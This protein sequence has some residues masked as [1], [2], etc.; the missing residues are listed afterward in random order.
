MDHLN[1]SQ[2]IHYSIPHT[3]IMIE[4]HTR[5]P[6][7][8]TAMRRTLET[9]LNTAHAIMDKHGNV[10]M[11][12]DPL[13]FTMPPQLYTGLEI[14]ARSTMVPGL[15]WIDFINVIHGLEQLML[16]RVLYKEVHV[17]MFDYPSGLQMGEVEL[18]K[19]SAVHSADH[20]D[21]N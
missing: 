10:F 4:I 20:G 13:E 2:I 12:P 3:H 9:C 8:A 1:A 5:T 14:G 18:Y 16:N 15:K 19:S 6:I 11:F 21:L 17:K 7:S